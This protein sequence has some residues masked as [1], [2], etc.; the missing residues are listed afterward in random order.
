MGIWLELGLFVVVIVF[1]LWQLH[2]VSKAREATRRQR[3]R[4]EAAR[5]AADP[6]GPKDG[7]V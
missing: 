1:A 3:E 6:G 2:D 5:Q 4:E 7:S